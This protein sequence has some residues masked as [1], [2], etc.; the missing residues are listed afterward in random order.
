MN[1]GALMRSRL[2]VTAVALIVLGAALV[3]ILVFTPASDTEER[4]LAILLTTAIVGLVGTLHT[5]SKI[6]QL[7]GKVDDVAG[8]VNG[9]MS[10]ILDK[11]PDQR[12]QETPPSEGNPRT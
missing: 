5:S 1:L 11:V 2:I 4:S 9:R 7:D 12:G 6:D 3:L 8:N 10:Q